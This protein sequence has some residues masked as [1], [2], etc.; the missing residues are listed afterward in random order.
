MVAETESF[1]IN[2]FSMNF[3]RGIFSGDDLDISI[4]SSACSYARGKPIQINP[5]L[6]N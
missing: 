2:D 5:N 6:E 3:Q 1:M 4:I